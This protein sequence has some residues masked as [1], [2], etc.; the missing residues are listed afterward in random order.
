ML[1]LLPKMQKAP[2]ILPFRFPENSRICPPRT[3]SSFSPRRILAPQGISKDSRSFSRH[4]QVPEHGMA[5]PILLRTGSACYCRIFFQLFRKPVPVDNFPFVFKS[6]TSHE[7]K[8][9]IVL[10][11]LNEES[12]RFS[13]FSLCLFAK[14]CPRPKE[15]YLLRY[16]AKSMYFAFSGGLSPKIFSKFGASTE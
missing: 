5:L 11:F 14:I 7:P 9:E 1:S 6:V 2:P 16:F 13:S 4:Q 12:S 15:M 10:P 8:V 3:F